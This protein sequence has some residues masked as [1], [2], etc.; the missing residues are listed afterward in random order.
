MDGRVEVVRVWWEPCKLG[1]EGEGGARLW[2]LL[3]DGCEGTV[4]WWLMTGESMWASGVSRKK[5]RRGRESRWPRGRWNR[6]KTR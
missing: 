2:S 1:A 3:G 4:V 5:K 6:W